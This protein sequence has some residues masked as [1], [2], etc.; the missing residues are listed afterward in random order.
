M[1]DNL[2]NVKFWRQKSDIEESM[3]PQNYKLLIKADTK[4]VENLKYAQMYF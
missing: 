3:K 1:F 4:N 2:E